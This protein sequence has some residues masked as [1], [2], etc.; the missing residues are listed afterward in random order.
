MKKTMITICVLILFSISCLGISE[1]SD[2][3][4]DS[5]SAIQRSNT[6]GDTAKPTYTEYT[7]GHFKYRVTENDE[8]V[9]TNFGHDL[10]GPWNKLVIPNKIDGKKVVGADKDIFYNPNW[11]DK[12]SV[13]IIVCSDY[14][15]CVDMSSFN[16][17]GELT[18]IKLGKYTKRF[19]VLGYNFDGD[20]LLIGDYKI[21]IA[22]DAKYLKVVKGALYSKDGS[23]LYRAPFTTRGHGEDYVGYKALKNT[24]RIAKH[25]FSATPYR[26]LKLGRK[27]TKIDRGVIQWSHINK[28]KVP[29]KLYKKYM[30]ILGRSGVTKKYRKDFYIKIVK[31]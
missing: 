4:N 19:N 31:Y 9:I 24:K 23:V 12:D 2:K 30:K 17:V 21:R 3:T 14:M 15:R 5:R 22:S 26:S 18:S 13:S 10:D 25:A 27:I 8:I 1:A 29:A 28:I 7:Y 16:E 11:I 6:A 20:R